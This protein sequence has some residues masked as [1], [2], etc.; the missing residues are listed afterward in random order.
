[1][2]QYQFPLSPEERRRLKHESSLIK[3]RRQE[4]FWQIAGGR[5]EWEAVAK[6]TNTCVLCREERSPNQSIERRE[7]C[8]FHLARFDWPRR[9]YERNIMVGICVVCK[10]TPAIEEIKTHN[11]YMYKKGPLQE[12]QEYTTYKV[13]CENCADTYRREYV[14]PYLQDCHWRVNENIRRLGLPQVPFE[15]WINEPAS[16]DNP[17]GTNKFHRKIWFLET[18]GVPG[19]FAEFDPNKVRTFLGKRYCIIFPCRGWPVDNNPGC[20]RHERRIFAPYRWYTYCG[21][22]TCR[23]LAAPNRLLC[24]AH[25]YLLN[26]TTPWPKEVLNYVRRWKIPEKKVISPYYVRARRT[27][28]QQVEYNQ[29]L[30]K[31]YNIEE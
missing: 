5:R 27:P 29:M 7:F 2:P 28:E 4:Y 26:P 1:M 13:F 9:Q 12:K 17:Y 22:R 21:L 11:V 18:Y 25:E 30:K 24:D 15:D 16:S 10:V 20:N 6:R 23:R 19:Y 3:Q 8:D 14:W 31:L